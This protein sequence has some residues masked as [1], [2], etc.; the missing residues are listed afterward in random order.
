MNRTIRS[1]IVCIVVAGMG[2]GCASTPPFEAESLGNPLPRGQFLVTLKGQPNALAAIENR[3]KE[4]ILD[5]KNGEI[6][7]VC[8]L[9]SPR[10][11]SVVQVQ[12]AYACRLPPSFKSTQA[13]DLAGLFGKAYGQ[14]LLDLHSSTTASLNDVYLAQQNFPGIANISMS[15]KSECVQQ[16]C[17]GYDAVWHVKC[18]WLC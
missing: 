5:N 9:I 13:S 15:N 6:A 2:A 17:Y 3:I 18:Y 16:V 12:L 1:G 7:K 14:A 11:Q 8:E 4:L 10:T